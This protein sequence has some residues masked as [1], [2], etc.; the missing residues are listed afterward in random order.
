MGADAMT[1]LQV[2]LL[3]A[4]FLAL[5]IGSFIFYITTWDARKA[6]VLTPV[7]VLTDLVPSHAPTSPTGDTL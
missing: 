7:I 5:T 3:I 4:A 1:N 2:L 6:Q